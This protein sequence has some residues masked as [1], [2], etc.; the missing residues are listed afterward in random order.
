MLIRK[1]SITRSMELGSPWLQ[2]TRAQAPSLAWC[3]RCRTAI[4]QSS[5]RAAPPMIS[6]ARRRIAMTPSVLRCRASESAHALVTMHRPDPRSQS[7]DRPTQPFIWCT[8]GM[9]LSQTYPIAASMASGFPRMVV[10]R[11]YMPPLLSRAGG[12]PAA[13]PHARESSPP[14]HGVNASGRSGRGGSAAQPVGRRFLLEPGWIGFRVVGPAGWPRDPRDAAGGSHHEPTVGEQVEAPAA[15]EGLDPVVASAQATEVPAV[16]RTPVAV[17]QAVVDVA[18][19]GS[20]PATG[21][22]ARAIARPD[23]PPLLCCRP[24]SHRARGWPESGA[25]GR[26]ALHRGASR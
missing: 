22:A 1:V 16:G 8:A 10:E 21:H 13:P 17:G 3:T 24:V 11:A 4:S 26:R 5:T 19:P 6:S 23:E 2:M 14:A 20:T 15:G 12:T 9:T 7:M 25:L 18:A